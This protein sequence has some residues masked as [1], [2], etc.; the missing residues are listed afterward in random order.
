MTPYRPPG[1]L[2]SLAC[3]RRLLPSD[4]P[5]IHQTHIGLERRLSLILGGGNSTVYALSAFL[6]YPMIEGLGRRK[7]FLWSVF[8]TDCS[9]KV[10]R[11]LMAHPPGVQSDKQLQ[12]SL[13]GRVLFRIIFTMTPKTR[14]STG[15]LQDYSFSW[16]S[17]GDRN[18]RS[19][20][21]SADVV[22]YLQYTVRTSAVAA[23]RDQPQRNPH[24]R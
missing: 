21:H 2:H 24:Q 22:C 20:H 23:R 7:M 8:R 15:R 18:A 5:A 3:I 16:R 14:Q 13:R 11:E 6:S 1:Y 12:C 17:D 19:E 9:L 10:K 4:R